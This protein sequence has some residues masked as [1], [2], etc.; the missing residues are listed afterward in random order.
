[1]SQRKDRKYAQKR[2]TDQ[3]ILELFLQKATG[4]PR[5]LDEE[6]KGIWKGALISTFLAGP[7]VTLLPLL[8]WS[9]LIPAWY[10]GIPLGINAAFL[11]VW[12]VLF[13]L[14]FKK[15]EG[16]IVNNPERLFHFVGTGA[17]VYISWIGFYTSLMVMLSSIGSFVRIPGAPWWIPPLVYGTSGVGLWMG[18]KEILRAIIEGTEAHPWFRPIRLFFATS[19]GFLVFLAAVLRIFLNWL[20]QVNVNIALLLFTALLLALS[21]LLFGL[22]M[23]GVILA[24]LHYQK[25]CGAKELRI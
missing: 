15:H 25:W 22:T 8:T 16:L 20:E 24:H 6:K 19:L 4:R 17:F 7:F 5:S 11:L 9:E 12:A 23:L 14:A 2:L 3:E 10:F 18:R 13:Y 1:M 21:V